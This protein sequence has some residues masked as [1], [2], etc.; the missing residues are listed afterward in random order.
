[1]DDEKLRRPPDPM[2]RY[3][4]RLM[5]YVM[6]GRRGGQRGHPTSVPHTQGC[7]WEVATAPGAWWVS[8]SMGGVVE[9]A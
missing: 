3:G 6:V 1:M 9:D 5:P 7:V 8:P 2:D 4:A